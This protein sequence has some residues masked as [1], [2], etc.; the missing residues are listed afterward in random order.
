VKYPILIKNVT[1][2]EAV[3]SLNRI[4]DFVSDNGY[5]D[6]AEEAWDTYPTIVTQF[7]SNYPCYDELELYSRLKSN[8]VIEYYR[9]E[10]CDIAKVYYFR[11]Y[12]KIGTYIEHSG[13]LVLM[14]DPVLA[15][16]L[17]LLLS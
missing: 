6:L 9:C 7:H 14:N 12:T 1:E 17:K 13:T 11:Y 15:V 3:E 2:P 10:R 4:K 16:Q 5:P 8:E